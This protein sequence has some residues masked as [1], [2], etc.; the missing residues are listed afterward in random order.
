MCERDDG[1][2]YG[3]KCMRWQLRCNTCGKECWFPKVRRESVHHLWRIFCESGEA[4]SISISSMESVDDA[5][6]ISNGPG[7]WLVTETGYKNM[8]SNSGY[9]QG[10]SQTDHFVT[11]FF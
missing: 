7:P 1:S 11:K 2:V 5:K 10:L 8:V 6:V 3:C 9:L 4:D